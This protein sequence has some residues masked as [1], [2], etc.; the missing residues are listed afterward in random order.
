[1]R[2]AHIAEPLIGVMADVYLSVDQDQA[3]QEARIS[4]FSDACDSAVS[5]GAEIILLTGRLFADSYVTDLTIS[6]VLDVIREKKAVFVWKPDANGKRY[7]AHKSDIP[8]N[9]YLLDPDSQ[10]EFLLRDA[11]ITLWSGRGEGSDG[12]NILIFDRAPELNPQ[13]LSLVQKVL[14]K[15]QYIAAGERVYLPKDGSFLSK[16]VPKLEN[17]GFDDEE[18]SGYF[19]LELSEK[20]DEPVSLQKKDAAFYHFHQIT[21]DVETEDDYGA[22][23]R[24]CAAATS[25]LGKHDCVRILLRGKV[26]VEAF[27]RPDSLQESLKPRFFYLEIFNDCRLELD[28]AAYAGDISLKGEFI[29][30]VL[31]EDSLSE[32]EKSRII[33]CGWN[34]LRGKELSE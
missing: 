6:R 11:H 4:A 7:L 13:N 33:Q 31:S 28:E 25:G 21:V 12:C 23:Y 16:H 14:P 17:T 30:M 26:D 18:E 15:I 9:F 27:I 32:S 19:L 29:R 10:A 22:V 5:Q 24:K 2:I 8:H 34:A 3:W 20:A 1:M